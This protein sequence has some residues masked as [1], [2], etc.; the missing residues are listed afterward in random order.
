VAD[1]LYQDLKNALQEFKDFLHGN[2]PTIK[3]AYQALRALVPRVDD[4]VNGLIDV[5]GKVRAEIARLDV[6]TIPHLQDVSTFVTSSRTFLQT[7]K[8]LLPNE[9]GAIDEVLAVTDVVSGLPSL[10]EVKADIL[11]LVD[12]I[13]A[14]LNAL[15]A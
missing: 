2:I 1:N 10:D 11:S 12:A 6:T 9:S 15:K 5:L 13:V 8:T 14:D 3:P 7:A 4:L